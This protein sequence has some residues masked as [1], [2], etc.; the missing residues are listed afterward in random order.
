MEKRTY[1]TTAVAAMAAT[2]LALPATV[3]SAADPDAASFCSHSDGEMNIGVLVVEMQ[4]MVGYDGDGN[5]GNRMP[6]LPRYAQLC[7]PH[8]GH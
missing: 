4:R 6:F 8:Y 5:P 7:N 1:I 2:G 3:A